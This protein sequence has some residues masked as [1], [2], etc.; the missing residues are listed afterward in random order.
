MTV[1]EEN[2]VSWFENF[3]LESIVTPVKVDELRAVLKESE[4]H[5]QDPDNFRFLIDG[6]SNRFKLEF[7]G[8]RKNLRQTTLNLK[9]TVGDK[10]I[11]WE[12]VMKEVKLKRYAGPF[13]RPLYENYIQSPIGLVPKDSGKSVRL[14]F[15]LSCPRTGNQKSVNAGIPKGKCSVKYPDFEQAIK[16]CQ[17]AGKSAKAVKSDMSSAF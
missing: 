1:N 8:N 9:F 7:E 14:I 11:L 6:F 16:L 13:D 5:K 15:H 2:E 3:D 17:M 12:K 4:Y 10:F